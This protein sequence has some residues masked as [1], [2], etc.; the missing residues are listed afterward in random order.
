MDKKF[1]DKLLLEEKVYDRTTIEERL[2]KYGFNSI[3]KFELFLWDLEMF[4]QI[5]KE[6]GS[7]IIL[8]GGAATQFYIPIKNQRTSVDIDMI[9]LA[10]KEEIESLVSVIESRFSNTEGYFKFKKHIPKHP[11]IDLDMLT[12]Y[13]V[14]VPTIC[15]DKELY[16]SGGRQ[17]VKIEFIHSNDTYPINQITESELFALDTSHS[18]NI[19]GLA[20]LF[21]DKLTTIGPTTIGITDDRMDEQFKQVYDVITL[22]MTNKAYLSKHMGQ[23]KDYY[24]HIAKNECSIRGIVYDNEKLYRDMLN[25]AYKLQK[26]E[27]DSQ[28]MKK[29]NDFQSMYL[30][31]DVN[32]DK[33][34]WAIIGFQLELIVK[35]IFIGDEKLTQL[36]D[37]E[38]YIVKCQYQEFVGPERGKMLRIL[39]QKFKGKFGDNKDLTDDIFRRNTERIIW[40]LVCK[41]D[42]DQIVE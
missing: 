42:L 37:I 13:F 24:E 28:Y 22:F 18:F 32:R 6:L 3:G 30:R 5:Q 39:R 21:A 1:L 40:E 10:S 31:K 16:S 7:K 38:K 34:G 26:I 29:A 23:I 14:Q 33:S 25:L 15:S 12:T 9:C 35:S 17:E 36:E 2:K 27:S 41:Y 11:K 4:L 19:L 20:Y 8:K